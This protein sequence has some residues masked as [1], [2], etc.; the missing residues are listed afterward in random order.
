MHYRINFLRQLLDLYY[1]LH[2]TDEEI[3]TQRS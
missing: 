1:Y 2:V 3:R